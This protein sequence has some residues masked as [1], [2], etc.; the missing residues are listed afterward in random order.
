VE[1]VVANST[2]AGVDHYEITRTRVNDGTTTSIIPL[3]IAPS[4]TAVTDA[5]QGLSP[6]ST[7]Q[8]SI[9]VQQLGGARSSYS[10]SVVDVG[11][12]VVTSLG[13][14]LLLTPPTS[15]SDGHAQFGF[16]ACSEPNRLT[17]DFFPSPVGRTFAKYVG[18]ARDPATNAALGC[19]TV[20]VRDASTGDA[21]NLFA[22]RYG[23]FPSSNPVYADEHGRFEFYADNGTYTVDVDGGSTAYSLTDVGVFDARTAQVA[24]SDSR[25]AMTLITSDAPATGDGNIHIRLTRPNSTDIN[26]ELGPNVS[27]LYRLLANENVNAWALTYNLDVDEASGNLT[28]DDDTR[29]S[30]FFRVNQVSKALEFGVDPRLGAHSSP[31]PETLLHVGPD[32]AHLKSFMGPVAFE[33]PA[34][35]N[36]IV[37]GN[38]VYLQSNGTAKLTGSRQLHPFIV[39]AVDTAS[40][41]STV[42]SPLYLA[43]GGRAP[44][45]VSGSYAVGEPLIAQTGGTAVGSAAQT[46]LRYV[47]GYSLEAG[48]GNGTIYAVAR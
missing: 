45:K 23:L 5:G 16:A 40:G 26:E 48:T 42:G 2:L 18:E 11:N 13:A 46:D 33:A 15:Q 6:G 25:A 19:A 41:S 30:F 9:T 36:G 8:Y 32:R 12:G 3:S 24:N 35:Q 37:A 4:T 14:N 31:V 44:V 38:V 27:R 17:W 20:T 34:A 47:L 21:I 43:M 22:D 10:A 39:L 28:A 1:L 7:Y 29:T